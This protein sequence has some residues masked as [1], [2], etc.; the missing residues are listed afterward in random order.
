MPYRFGFKEPKHFPAC[1]KS[2]KISQER[3]ADTKSIASYK[4]ADTTGTYQDFQIGVIRIGIMNSWPFDTRILSIPGR[5]QV[6]ELENFEIS[7]EGV[8]DWFIE[9]SCKN[10]K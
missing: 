2:E 1:I 4:R 5:S 6:K 7:E 8:I 9:K 10:W 3:A